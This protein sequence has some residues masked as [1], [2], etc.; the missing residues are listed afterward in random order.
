M[1]TGPSMVLPKAYS[2]ERDFVGCYSSGISIILPIGQIWLT[3]H[4]Y[5]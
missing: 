1:S 5:K 4:V 3:S 2:V